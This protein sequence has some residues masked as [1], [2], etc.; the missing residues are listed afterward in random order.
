MNEIFM[1]FETKD[2]SIIMFLDKLSKIRSVKQILA[3]L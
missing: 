3:E 1:Q 2:S